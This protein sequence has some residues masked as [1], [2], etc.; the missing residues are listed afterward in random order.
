M[1][2]SAQRSWMRFVL[3][4]AGAYNLV[5]GMAVVLFPQAPFGWLGLP[6]PNYVEIWQCLGMVVGVYGV[7]YLI[8]SFDPL[9]H[10]PMIL[11]GLLGKV[12]VPIGFAW[13]ASKGSLP[14]TAGW[15][16]VT[17]DLIWWVPFGL[18]LNATYRDFLQQHRS[19]SREVLQLALRTK[20]NQEMTLLEMSRR[21]PTMVV[22]L[23]HTG[24]TFC[25]EAAADIARQRRQIEKNET[26]IVLVYMGDEA[27]GD[28][29]FSK[30]GLDDLPRVSD[31][32]A[33][34]YRAFG[35]GRGSVGQLFG[36]AVWVRGFQAGIVEGHG[37]GKLEGD[38]FQMPGVFLLFHGAVLRSFVHQSAADR[39]DYVKFAHLDE[40]VGAY[41]IPA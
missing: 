40:A 31:P 32:S 6:Y 35:L 39:L 36:P 7:G 4:A 26:R 34:L 27:H 24:C 20:T 16:I 25:R 30:Y 23:R 22:F 38:G 10:W 15:T 9:R 13:A 3:W 28:R 21:W 19:A 17:N 8:A 14:W 29:F 5:W 12:L 1:E 11:V 18:I 37:V 41:Q 33:L 2:D